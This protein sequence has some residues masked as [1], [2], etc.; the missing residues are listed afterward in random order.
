MPSKKKKQGRSR[1]GSGSV[2]QVNENLWCGACTVGHRADTGK[3][4][5][6][7]VYAETRAEAE[8]KL[9]DLLRKY[10][11]ADAEADLQRA[12][13]RAGFRLKHALEF[14]LDTKVKTQVD[15]A[16]YQLHH[17]RITDHICPHLGDVPVAGLNPYL[18]KDWLERLAESGC[19]ADLCNKVG[20][21]LRRCLDQCIE[22]GYIKTNP[23]RRIPLPRVDRAE[24]H[25]LDEEQV[26]QFLA[27]ARGHRLYPLWLLAL[28]TGMRQ[29][30]IIALEWA[31]VDMEAGIVSIT[32]SAR[33]ADKGGQRIKEVKT[34]ASRRRIR[35][36]R[37]T[38]EALCA[39]RQRS[40]GP[41]VFATRGR[42]VHRGQARLL[43]KGSLLRAFRKLLRKAG[44]PLLRFH[45]LRHTHA[46][47]ALLKL[48][49]VK[50]VSARLGH[51]DI[52]VTLNTYSHYLPI[53]EEEYVSAME[54]L[55]SPQASTEQEVTK[56]LSSAG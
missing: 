34:K 12:E 30:E 36:T 25:P 5:R 19:S 7:K 33:T 15:S 42:G 40:R 8:A 47:L 24:M 51:A 1:K 56:E 35:L 46:T 21:L 23:A 10:Q 31:D 50:A 48:R 32:K 41:L 3:A 55:L 52:R 11:G 39:W 38:L 54:G 9:R 45:D 49:N 17:Q 13:E 43:H 2:Y 26:K 29:G 18:V 53:M 37:A 14:W 28:D 27:V 16:T 20:Q 4:I 44:L 22:Y 6:K